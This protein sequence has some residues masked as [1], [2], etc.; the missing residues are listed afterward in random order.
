[1]GTDNK[2]K[3]KQKYKIRR[4][5]M[6]IVNHANNLFEAGAMAAICKTYAI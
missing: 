6:L 5:E 1:M 4:A 2:F 3:G